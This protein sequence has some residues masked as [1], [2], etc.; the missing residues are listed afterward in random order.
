[1]PFMPDEFVE[2]VSDRY[3]ELFEKIT[4]DRFIKADTERISTRVE[5]NIAAWLQDNR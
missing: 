5:T 3:I 4:G 1:M 2:T